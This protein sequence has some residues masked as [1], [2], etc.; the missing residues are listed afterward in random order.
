MISASQAYT[1]E[2]Q[3]LLDEG[4]AE[5]L[6]SGASAGLSTPAGRTVVSAGTHALDDAT[7]VGP[8]SLFDLASVSKT[9][10]AA[11]VLRLAELGRVD[12]DAP[13]ARIL[14]IGRGP[15]ADDITLRMLLLHVSGLPAESFVWRDP[16]VPPD[17]RV[18]R[19]LASPL[20]SRPNELYRYS[21]VGY[22]AA[23]A[24]I[25]RATGATL[26]ELLGDLV[27]GPLGLMSVSYGP[28]DVARAVATEE[29]PWVGRGM[30][31][32]EVHD[33]LNRFLGG[34]VGNAGLFA[35]AEDILAFAESF[36]NERL[37][38]GGR[39]M[40]MVTDGLSESH[41]SSFGQGL[42]PRIRDRESFGELDGYGH[43]GFTGTLWVVDPRRQVAGVLL[44]NSVHPHR[45]HADFS[46]FRRRFGDWVATTFPSLGV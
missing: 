46:G 35:T 28:V 17:E 10:T 30:L 1:A 26:Q 11:V 5:R 18:A 44:T 43:I 4:V 23:G 27:T 6:Y 36:L 34:K 22:I 13:V 32:G 9:F 24:V 16:D 19:V 40:Q 37:F 2:L 14:P 42:G 21:C 41:G 29:Q 39:L 12:L 45:D 3:A 7:P 20:E 33:E 8:D 15:G 25:E 38:Q 31:R